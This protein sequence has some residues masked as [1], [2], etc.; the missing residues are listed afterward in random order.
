M[1]RQT[2]AVLG[3]GVFGRTIAREL[4]QFDQDVIV[5]DHDERHINAVADQVSKAA[6]GDITDLNFLKTL[7]IDQCDTAIVATGT[8]LESSA[9]AV[10]NCKKL[11]VKRIVAKA[12]NKAYEEVLYGIGA[13]LVVSPEREAAG[14]LVSTILRHKIQ[15]IFHFEGEVSLIEFEIP[16]SWTGKS[17][18]DLDLRKTFQMNVIGL[19]PQARAPLNTSID[20][21]QPLAHQ[22]IMVAIADTRLFEQYDYLDYF[23]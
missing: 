1:T 3:L 5:A 19:R 20:P 21:H 17:I 18:L 11:G 7:G 10:M 6:I 12:K 16:A 13:D 8:D 2:I 14:H 4:T 9:L 23:K 15:E 22:T